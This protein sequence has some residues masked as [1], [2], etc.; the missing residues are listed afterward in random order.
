LL[1][2]VDFEGGDQGYL[3]N[4][5]PGE[6]GFGQAVAACDF[7]GDGFADLAVG[8]P[9][10]NLGRIADA[11]AVRVLYGSPLGLTVTGNQLWSEDTP[12]LEGTA[13]ARDHFGAALVAGDFNHDGFCDLAVGVPD[14]DLGTIG[15][16]G[17]VQIL[18][19]SPSGLSA[20]N[21]QAWGQ[22]T[23]GVQGVAAAGDR[24]GAALAVG[25]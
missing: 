12:G 5:A 9:D 25:D 22:N 3:V 7:N 15:D 16:A 6:D 2:A 4:L 14:R 18:Y 11:G 10:E 1:R 23:Q 20:V 21:N 17:V 8:V 24:F 19:G 13:D